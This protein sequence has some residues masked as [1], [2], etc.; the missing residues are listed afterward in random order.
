MLVLRELASHPLA[1][2]Q[3]LA[4]PLYKTVE[5]LAKATGAGQ[6]LK[7]LDRKLADIVKK[8][9]N[10]AWGAGSHEKTDHLIAHLPELAARYGR[11]IVYVEFRETQKAIVKRLTLLDKETLRAAS[12]SHRPVTISYHGGLTR[13][14]KKHQ[15]ERLDAAKHAW[16][17]STDAGG[18]GLNLQKSQIVVNFDFPWNPMRVEQ[19][20]GRVDR[21]G[22]DSPVVTIKNYV[23][24]GTIEEYVY[25]ALREKLGVC[26]DV[27][28]RVIPRIFQLEGVH[29][30]YATP[31]DVLGI[32]QIILRSED[33]EDL[34]RRF[35]QFGQELDPEQAA[36]DKR[37]KPRQWRFDG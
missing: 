34:R 3:T 11:V 30:Q 5:Q 4:G 8:Y 35:R 27:L 26:E 37:W 15:I 14:G 33:E 13:D 18:Q 25:R 31:Y 7:I 24:L 2:Y 22:Q 32:G 12:L 28:G 29:A 1:A 20:I 21:I 6:D 23:T 17:I 19:R 10:A 36:G 9:K 16:F